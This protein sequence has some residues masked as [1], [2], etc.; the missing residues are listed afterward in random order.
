MTLMSK[1]CWGIAGIYAIKEQ[2]TLS[3]VA[4][5]IVVDAFNIFQPW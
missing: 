2:T 4:Q 5:M 3:N 1:R